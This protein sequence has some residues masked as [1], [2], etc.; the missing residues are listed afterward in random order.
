MPPGFGYA[1]KTIKK[2]QEQVLNKQNALNSIIGKSKPGKAVSKAKFKS[3]NP[4]I[5]Q[6]LMDRGLSSFKARQ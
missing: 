3:K 6:D 2:V 5:D 1:R 4:G